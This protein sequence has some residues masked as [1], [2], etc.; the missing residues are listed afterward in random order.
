MIRTRHTIALAVA[1]ALTIAACGGDDE[2]AAAVP[3]EEPAD[4]MSEE[5]M[6]EEEMS[7]EE[8][9]DE[10]MSEEEM[11]EEEMSDEEMSEEEMSD[12]MTVNDLVSRITARD[13][14]TVLDQAIHAA[15]LQDTL[16]DDGPFTIFAPTD[17][18]FEVYLGQMG[19][20]ADEVLADTDALTALLQAH[21]VAG[22]DDSAMVMGMDGQSFTT[23]AGTELTVTV[24]GETVMVGDATVVEYDVAAD[25]GVIHVI[26]TVL[27]PPAG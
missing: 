9:S 21:V 7:E 12:E 14:L 17:A 20:N 5:E 24:D 16:H 26:D 25:N 27:A 6:S 18:A 10:E 11:S 19:M 8:M 13:D 15:G 4:E 23:L 1:G 2:P 3:A 22:S